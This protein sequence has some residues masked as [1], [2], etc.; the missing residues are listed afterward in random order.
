MLCV[1]NVFLS[2]AYKEWSIIQ[3]KSYLR[4]GSFDMHGPMHI[5]DRTARGAN[6][7]T[8]NEY[9]AQYKELHVFSCILGDWRTAALSCR[10]E[11]DENRMC[12]SNPEPADPHTICKYIMWKCLSSGEELLFKGSRVKDINGRDVRPRIQ[13]WHSPQCVSKFLASIKALHEVYENLKGDYMDKCDSCL[14]LNDN[15]TSGIWKSCPDHSRLGAA[16]KTRG[17]VITND[18]VKATAQKCKKELDAKHIRKGSVRLL[19]AHVKTIHDHLIGKLQRGV[20]ENLWFLE[21]WVLI[22]VGLT[23]FLRANELLSLK[24]RNIRK[25]GVQIN[26]GKVRNLTVEVESSKADHKPVFLKLYRNDDQTW[27]C[28]VRWLLFYISQANLKEQDGVLFPSRNAL[29]LLVEGKIDHDS[30]T[31]A[32]QYANYLTMMKGLISGLFPNLLD[33]TH[34]KTIGTHTLRYLGYLFAVWGVLGVNLHQSEREQT[35]K[36]FEVLNRSESSIG[37]SMPIPCY[38]DI[39]NAARHTS[40]NSANYYIQ[41]CT[42]LFWQIQDQPKSIRD[43]HVIP[44]WKNNWIGHHLEDVS[45]FITTERSLQKPAFELAMWFLKND[46]QLP[47]ADDSRV[48]DWHELH[49]SIVCPTKAYKHNASVLDMLDGELEERLLASVREKFAQELEEARQACIEQGRRQEQGNKR[50]GGRRVNAAQ[51]T[52]QAKRQ[53]VSTVTPETTNTTTEDDEESID[54]ILERFQTHKREYKD[55]AENKE[56]FDMKEIHETVKTLCG[57]HISPSKDLTKGDAK[58]L[59]RVKLLLKGWERCCN[60][61]HNKDWTQFYQSWSG[62]RIKFTQKDKCGCTVC[63]SIND[64]NTTT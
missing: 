6:E 63:T 33:V 19:P 35:K 54:V 29:K 7:A 57:L 4:E 28:P 15:N 31:Q 32:L 24:V 60:A 39:M 42:S 64:N 13:Q 40:V 8:I 14:R 1:E 37:I 53:R 17:G 59:Q 16:I 9:H 55:M 11:D 52:P 62:Q 48:R 46:L 26:H 34:N 30:E 44:Y 27:L 23:C 58:W 20:K 45:A 10:H 56:V 12:P 25:E 2:P 3:I 41:G 61:N 50:G 5:V 21:C 18:D 38:C 51:Q 49:S 43:L 36:R 22:L 47:S